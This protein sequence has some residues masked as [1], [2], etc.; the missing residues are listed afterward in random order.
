[1]SSVSHKNPNTLEN[2]QSIIVNTISAAEKGIS[3]LGDSKSSFHTFGAN[4]KRNTGRQEQATQNSIH[5]RNYQG[6][7]ELMQ[8]NYET[9]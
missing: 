2:R 5:N 6:E 3:I 7:F 8:R 1:M 9:D 4:N